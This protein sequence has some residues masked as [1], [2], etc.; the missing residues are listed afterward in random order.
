FA[1]F[2]V[3]RVEMGVDRVITGAVV[4]DDDF[5]VALEGLGHGD[6]AENDGAHEC[7]ELD[8]IGVANVADEAHGVGLFAGAEGVIRCV[9]DQHDENAFKTVKVVNGEIKYGGGPGGLQGLVELLA[10]GIKFGA[11]ANA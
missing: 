8:K 9:Y 5:S 10:G 2:D 1:G 7:V 11:S 6:N 4:K 3:D